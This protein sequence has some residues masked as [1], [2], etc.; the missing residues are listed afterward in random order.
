MLSINRCI[1]KNNYNLAYNTNW[2]G[3][4]NKPISQD[5]RC[6]YCYQH[7]KLMGFENEMFALQTHG[8]RIDCDT[9]Y[10]K[11]LTTLSYN[12]FE[13]SVVSPKED[14]PFLV[15][16]A[17]ESVRNNGILVLEM[18]ETQDYAINI[19]P[20][21]SRGGR[22]E[23]HDFYYTFEMSVGSKK[24]VINDGSP[25]YYHCKTT[26]FGFQSGAGQ[27]FRF[28]ANTPGNG[29]ASTDLVDSNIITIK[30]NKFRRNRVA[31]LDTWQHPTGFRS[32]RNMKKA[33]NY[34]NSV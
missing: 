26:V 20:A 6:E 5:T 8:S 21:F 29:A 24:V 25:I 12:N 31:H 9:L 1:G 18:P 13:V 30:L 4:Y 28:V 15:H 2:Y 22:S 33:T 16:P 3:F 34:F 7:M 23:N 17:K 14:I 19:A 10:D 27:N 11:R 32:G